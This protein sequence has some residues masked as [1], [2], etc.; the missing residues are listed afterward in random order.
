M[1]IAV[2]GNKS[3]V[4]GFRLAGIQKCVEAANNIVELTRQFKELTSNE[5]IALL[6]IDDACQ[7]LRDEIIRFIEFNKKPV[8]V[9]IPCKGKRIEPSIFESIV[10]R[11]TGARGD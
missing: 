4:V 10:K 7:P 6:I 5:D 9:E 11:A 3:T 1:Q 2:L 8:I